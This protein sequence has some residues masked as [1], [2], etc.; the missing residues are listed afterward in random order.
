MY[1][2]DFDNDFEHKAVKE[3]CGGILIIELDFD[4]KKRNNILNNK[5]A[6]QK[7]INFI[8]DSLK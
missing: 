2:S 3:N 7:S 5:E 4:N 8:N 1:L 6:M